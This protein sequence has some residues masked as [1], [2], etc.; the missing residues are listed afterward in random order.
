MTTPKPHV[1]QDK[2]IQ[3]AADPGAVW[4]Y[5][6]GNKWISIPKGSNPSWDEDTDYR[7]KPRWLDMEQE[8]VAKGKPPVEYFCDVMGW[9]S[10]QYPKWRDD[11]EYRFK[12]VS[13]HAALKAEWEAKGKPQLQVQ[14]VRGYW[15][16][17]IVN[18][19]WSDDCNFRI[20]PTPHPNA[21]VLRALAEDGSLEVGYID[22]I[23]Q[24]WYICKGIIYLLRIK[25]NVGNDAK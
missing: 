16:D 12:E 21:E 8:W 17:A 4:Q 22:P 3:W 10:A 1:H 14:D 15:H 25:P 23:N 9:M 11:T 5:D 7:R 6:D 20:K 2:I 19:S 18:S 13:R 24:N